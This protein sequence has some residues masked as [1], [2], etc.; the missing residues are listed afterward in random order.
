MSDPKRE[1]PP[2]DQEFD[3][4]A[5]LWDRIAGDIERGVTP[6]AETVEKLLDESCRRPAGPPSQKSQ[7]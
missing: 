2:Q 5:E 6:C 3:T 7:D 4:T 1:N